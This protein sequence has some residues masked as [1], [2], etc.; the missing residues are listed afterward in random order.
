MLNKRLLLI[1]DDFDVADML[2][3][4][5]STHH[6]EVIH[7]ETGKIGVEKART[8]FPHL[9]LLDLMLP[10]MDGYGIFQLV[11][12]TAF[13][14]YIPVIFL[15]QR[16][17]AAYK[18]HGLQLGADDYVTKPFDVEELR[19][20]VQGSIQRATREHLH[21]PR[22]GLPTGRLI[23]EEIE[24]RRYER[25]PYHAL[26]FRIE[27]YDVFRDV[28]GFITANQV[29]EF[30]ARAIHDVVGERGTAHD[31]VG[32]DGDR[33]V[34]LTHTGDPR[35]LVRGIKEAFG[36]GIRA[37]YSFQDAERGGILVRERDGHELVS[38]M[39]SLAARK[40]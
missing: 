3:M 9:I 26:L 7:A 25:Q 13:T 6:Y 16:D 29:M 11:R 27:G 30:A 15:T 34:V 37:F 32:I 36:K 23:S 40:L 1:E 18:I 19:L 17:E 28:Y 14:R 22:T 38:P 24:R 4:Y 12:E 39:L 21:E 31:F 10:D 20:R 33:F 2:R 5:F 35:L 8:K